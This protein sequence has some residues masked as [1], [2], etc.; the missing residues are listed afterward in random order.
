ML[1]VDGS[2]RYLVLEPEAEVL[3]GNELLASHIDVDD[4]RLRGPQRRALVVPHNRAQFLA[5]RQQVVARPHEPSLFH[6]E[7]SHQ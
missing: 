5:R 4:D 1:W 6:F 2:C 7:M 3:A